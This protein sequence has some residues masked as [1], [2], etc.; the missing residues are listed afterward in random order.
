MTNP[1]ELSIKEIEVAKLNLQPGDT[2]AVTIKSDGLDEYILQALKDN[3]K[4]AFPNNRVLLF[5]VGE[6]DDIKF[7]AIS[8]IKE[9]NACSPTQYC[10]DCN[11]G[12]KESQN[13]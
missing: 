7:T 8:E 3:F 6:N 13:A 1:I 11:C 5:G 10:V 4:I 9:N 12:K 2:L